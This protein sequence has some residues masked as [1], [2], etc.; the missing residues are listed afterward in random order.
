M[1]NFAKRNSKS[2]LM[3]VVDAPER[4]VLDKPAPSEVVKMTV[5]M[6]VEDW[7]ELNMCAT[8]LRVSNSE[9]FRRMFQHWRETKQP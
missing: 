5:R 9:L 6:T 8:R 7:Q 2:D 3:A 4:D 1:S